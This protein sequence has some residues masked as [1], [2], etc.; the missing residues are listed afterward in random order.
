MKP[1]M[2]PF[3]CTYI[4]GISYILS[5]SLRSEFEAI[6]LAEMGNLRG[7]SVWFYCTH[8]PEIEDACFKCL[9]SESGGHFK[10][11]T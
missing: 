10:C 7:G 2:A 9:A 5:G 4:V 11:T 6:E 3:I 8:E 1:V